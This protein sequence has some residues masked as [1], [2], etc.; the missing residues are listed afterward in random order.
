MCHLHLYN[1]AIY[2]QKLYW[3]STELNIYNTPRM[4]E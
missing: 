4:V 3:S 2:N 1:T